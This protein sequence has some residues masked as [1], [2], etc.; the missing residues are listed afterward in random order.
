[1]K[2]PPPGDLHKLSMLELFGLECEDHTAQ[3]TQGLL[4]LERNPESPA[5]LEALMRAAHSL[6]GAARIAGLSPAAWIAHSLEDCFSAVQQGK[7]R[8]AAADV[9]LLF[10]G[11]DLLQALG[12]QS[13]G[14]LADWAE[15]HRADMRQFLDSVAR[16][17]SRAD[18]PQMPAVASLAPA[19]KPDQP[20]ALGMAGAGEV[21]PQPE[22]EETP[23]EPPVLAAGRPG[24]PERVVRLGAESL[25]RL[26]GLAGEALVAS[27]WLRPFA[28]DLQRLKQLHSNVRLRFDRLR[29]LLDEPGLPEHALQH[30][31]AVAGELNACCAALH[32]R[33]EELE[34][35]DRRTARLSHRLYLEVLRTRMRPFADLAQ[36]LPRLVRDLGRQLGKEVRLEI[37]GETTQVDR[38]ILEKLESPLV[39][40]LRN[41]VDHGCETPEARRRRGKPLPATVRVEARHRA[42][43]LLVTVSDDGAGVDTERLRQVLVARQL[44]PETQAR[45]MTGSELLHFLFLPGLTLK[46]AVTE[47][48]GRGVG[49]DVVHAAVKSVRG[50]VQIRSQ[51]GCGTEVQL[52][53]PLTLSV[54][55][56]LLVEVGHEPYALP[57]EQVR[58]TAEATPDQIKTLEGR[59]HFRWQQQFIG[60]VRAADILGGDQTHGTTAWPMVILGNDRACYGLLVDR[61][62]GARELAVQPLDARLGLV[63]PVC[64]AAILEDGRPV[65][66]LEV[67]ELL[68]LV[69]ARAEAGDRFQLEDAPAAVRQ[70]LTKRV[71]VVDDSPVARTLQSS[72]LERQGCQVDTAADGL[73][74]WNTL[75][76]GGYDLVITDVDMPRLDGLAL[77]RR[78]KQDARLGHLPVLILSHHDRDE[79]RRQGLEAGADGYF[80]KEGFHQEA[81]LRAVARLLETPNGQGRSAG[82]PATGQEG[83][84]P[85]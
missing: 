71:L 65:L 85:T 74:A 63:P 61:L 64:A 45:A 62:L 15:E 43:L 55:N 51:P 82:E 76:T 66:V 69:E 67:A 18:A 53:L 6:K 30:L 4:A 1:M 2:R 56:A 36:R 48:S 41:A 78:I 8:L 72:L 19:D 40:L 27:R 49:L 24:V 59:P 60:L 25:N 44:V 17:V 12:R 28:T 39:H 33:V 54:L 14:D 26:L 52:Q 3:L 11:V 20:A 83:H 34:S 37:A 58:Q 81:W 13:G 29:C 46:E 50:H 80:T 73:E 75:C 21:T 9:D 77:T 16:L 68:R 47:V 35:F 32:R 23:A 57:L 7:L 22:G 70:P 42:G 84:E 31:Q 5:P 38:D 10:R 79:Q